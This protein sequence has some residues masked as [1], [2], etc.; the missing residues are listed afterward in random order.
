M[1]RIASLLLSVL[2]VL[3]FTAALSEDGGP[4]YTIPAGLKAVRAHLDPSMLPADHPAAVVPVS[5]SFG[6]TFSVELSGP[7]PSLSVVQYSDEG[8]PVILATAE[9]AS[10]LTTDKVDASLGMADVVLTWTPAGGT[11]VS[12]WS[13]WE[14]SSI[15][16]LQCV[17]TGEIE[18]DQYAPYGK[19]SRYIG[20]DER[21]NV[22]SDNYVLSNGLDTFELLLEYDASGSLAGYGLKWI[23]DSAGTALAFQATADSVPSMIVYHDANTDFTAVSDT[24]PAYASGNSL[25]LETIEYDPSYTAALAAAYPQLPEP[26]QDYPIETVSATQTDLAGTGLSGYLWCLRFGPEGSATAPFV[27]PDA[28][29]I[30]VGGC[31]VLNSEAKDLNGARPDFPEMDFSL[32]AMELPV[33]Q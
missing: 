8:E 31:P 4:E 26:A 18:G 19:G 2:L 25:V 14:D 27:T 32:P 16:F 3:A 17:W 11:L 6:S 20:F 15:D 1:K 29:F 28:L 9:N 7:V 10:S 13:V 23:L 12:S 30:I 22:I 33:V 24:L 21:M 5:A